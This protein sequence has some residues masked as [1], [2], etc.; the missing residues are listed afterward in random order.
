MD[1]IVLQLMQPSFYYSTAMMAIV[2]VISVLLIRIN[3]TWGAGRKSVLLVAPMGAALLTLL[4]FPPSITVP[5]AMEFLPH[6]LVDAQAPPGVAFVPATGTAVRSVLSITGT[7]GVVGLIL[8]ALSVAVSLTFSARLTRRLLQVVDLQRTDFPELTSDVEEIAGR[9]GVPVP[10]IG[11]VEDLRPN[12]FT[13]GTGRGA[14]VVFSLGVLTVLDR[15]E[16]QAVAAHELAHI[17]NRD[18]WF[19]ASTKA[20]A[21]MFFFHPAAHL[22]ARAAHRERERLADETAGSVMGERASLIRA[23]EKV[24]TICERDTSR[25]SLAS[26]FGL[27]MTLSLLE[28]GSLMSDH[29]S[30]ADRTR[31]FSDECIRRRLGPTACLL[32]SLAVVLAGIALVVSMGEVRAD[33]LDSVLSPHVPTEVLPD[34]GPREL[35]YHASWDEGG[36]HP[37]IHGDR[38]HFDQWARQ[39]TTICHSSYYH[40]K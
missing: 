29:P 11:L 17:K 1:Q 12:A 10:R 36:H 8:G 24:T 13:F 6:Q 21:W 19:K 4:L 37:L 38:P 7:L 20:L 30:L 33:I 2:M 31:Q 15:L 5:S 32:L 35:A 26:R 16:L 14:T 22:A 3:G 28:R 9:L 25:P 40:S 39:N 34:L 23:I 27:S 18:L